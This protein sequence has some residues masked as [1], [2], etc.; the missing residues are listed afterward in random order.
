MDVL[1]LLRDFATESGFAKLFEHGEII[2][3][4]I[5]CFLIYRAW[6]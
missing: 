6:F 1:Q 2:M 3:I 4:G 5:A